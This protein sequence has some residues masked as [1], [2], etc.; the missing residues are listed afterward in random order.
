MLIPPI[1]FKVLDF[2]HFKDG[3]RFRTVARTITRPIKMIISTSE[4]LPL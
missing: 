4:T 1:Q 3:G 2:N